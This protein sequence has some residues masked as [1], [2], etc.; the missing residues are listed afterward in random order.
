ML[1]NGGQSIWSRFAAI[2]V[3]LD[4]FESSFSKAKAD[5]ESLQTMIRDHLSL[6]QERRNFVLTVLAAIFLPLSFVTSLFGMNMTSPTQEGPAS[7]SAWV[8]NT[9]D[10]L[11]SDL[12]DQ[13]RT[14]VSTIST[15]GTLT[16]TWTH[17]AI[18]AVCLTMTLPISLTRG[19][20]V[21]IVVHFAQHYRT[22][23]RALAIPPSVVFVFLSIFGKYL[24]LYPMLFASWGANGL[25][26]LFEIGK[27]YLAWQSKSHRSF[28]TSI[29]VLTAI[30][31]LFEMLGFFV[32]GSIIFGYF[33]WMLLPWVWIIFRWIQSVRTNHSQRRHDTRLQYPNIST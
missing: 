7:F 1:W 23:W 11:P 6:N 17:F 8:N 28:W 32:I 13:T 31:F 5:I 9:I 24:R 30:C 20:L 4:F 18:F 25:L 3:D 19:N 26:L 21:R 15:S 33:P 14:L 29:L 2:R 16:W 12:G 10:G 22:Y 27:V